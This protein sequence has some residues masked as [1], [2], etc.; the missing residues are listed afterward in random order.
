MPTIQFLGNE[1]H[2]K[3]SNSVLFYALVDGREIECAISYEAL[4]DHFQADYY[5]LLPVFMAN[6][7]VILQI[8]EKLII[9]DRLENEGKRVVIRSQDMATFLKK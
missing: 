4:R 2:D 6:Q 8:N 1:T 5:N 7:Q 9:E 3:M